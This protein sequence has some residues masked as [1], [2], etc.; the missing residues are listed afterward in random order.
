MLENQSFEDIKIE[1][2]YNILTL[3]D[4]S[5]TISDFKTKIGYDYFKDFKVMINY[6]NITSNNTSKDLDFFML[7][8]N[9]EKL[10][11]IYTMNNKKVGC[12]YEN[13]RIG[14]INALLPSF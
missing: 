3:E 7:V 14:S 10:T 5:L 1:S 6:V 4:L 9:K 12:V 13:K 11:T 8:K 2:K